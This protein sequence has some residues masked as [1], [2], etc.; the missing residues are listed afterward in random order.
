M[1]RLQH[2]V[3]ALVAIVSI[4]IGNNSFAACTGA[5]PNWSSTA[6]YRSVKSCV[7]RAAP[8]DKITIS[9]NATWTRTLTLTRGIT[10]AG[11]GSPT[12]TSA[13][14]V[15]YWKPSPAAQ[16]AR[17]TMSI[18]G[19]IFDGNESDFSGTGP[20]RAYNSAGLNYVNLISKNN[21]IRN[22]EASKR[23]LN[24]AGLIYCVAASKNW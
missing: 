24:L 6:D 17:E 9:G 1:K 23:G 7:S 15:F 14:A 8:G 20:I 22:V 3:F 5:S 2:L 4:F 21:T 18:S 12:I 11:S 10:L 19:F 13:V 16:T